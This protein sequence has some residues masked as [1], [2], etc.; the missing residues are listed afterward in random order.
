MAAIIVLR[1]SP[2]MRVI[3]YIHGWSNEINHCAGKSSMSDE[4]NMKFH[5]WQFYWKCNGGFLK[6]FD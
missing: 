1:E 2:R 6:A 4:L 3:L 5:W